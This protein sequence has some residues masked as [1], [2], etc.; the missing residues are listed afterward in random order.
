MTLRLLLCLTCLSVLTPRSWSQT[1]DRDQ[2]VRDLT[3]Y[4]AAHP[5]DPLFFQQSTHTESAQGTGG[6]G[7]ASGDK[8]NQTFD[9]SAPAL[10]LPGGGGSTGG[11]VAS[12]QSAMS[13]KNPVRII[14]AIAG[15]LGLGVAAWFVYRKN[16]RGAMFAGAA[17]AGFIVGALLPDFAL[18]AVGGG[19]LVLML[20]HAYVEHTHPESKRQVRDD[21]RRKLRDVEARLG[22]DIDHDG[23][24]GNPTAAGGS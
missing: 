20:G 12:K 24:I 5:N 2:I 8:A 23:A 18:I 3:K 13:A 14:M 15:V 6:S 7:Q 10:S 9:G 19:A 4:H 17:G 16:P 11:D 21:L 1:A 22:I